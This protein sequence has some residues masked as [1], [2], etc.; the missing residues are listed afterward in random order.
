MRLAFIFRKWFTEGCIWYFGIEENISIDDIITSYVLKT[1]LLN[2]LKTNGIKP[3]TDELPSCKHTWAAAIYGELHRAMGTTS[4]LP[5]YDPNKPM[6]KCKRCLPKNIRL[7]CRKRVLTKQL[8]FKMQTFLRQN[9]DKL[10][11]CHT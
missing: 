8:A 1:C 3:S 10:C 2:I 6:W 5:W 4:L 11:N 7:C 9:W